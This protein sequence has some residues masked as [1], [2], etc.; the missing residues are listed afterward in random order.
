MRTPRFSLACA[1]ALLMLALGCNKQSSTAAPT[2]QQ[3]TSNVQAKLQSESALAGQNIQVAASNGVVTLTGS[4]NDAASRALAGNDAGAVPGV[5]TVVNNLE[6]QPAT[7]AAAAPPPAAEPEPAPAPQP[8]HRH[9]AR[10]RPDHPA[11]TSGPDMSQTAYNTP[12]PAPAPAN[13]ATSAPPPPPAPPVPIQRT[14]TLAA[15]TVVPVRITEALDS[16]HAQPD[17]AFHGTLAADLMRNG[18]V[19]IP[20]GTPVLGRVVDAKS[21]AHFKGSSL[22]SI[23]LTRIDLPGNKMSVFTDAFSKEGAGRGKNTAEKAGGGALLGTV[24]GALAGGGK[25][26]AIGAIAGAGAGTGINAATHGQQVQI[27]SETLIN[28]TL[29]QPLSFTVTVTPGGSAPRQPYEPT[30]NQRPP[31]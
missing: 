5:K 20:Q 3:L 14:I 27:P 16:E 23:E 21:A 13:S 28:F 25:G 1:A 18:T 24:I 17:Q 8:R 31:Q 15:G 30:L 9:D 26:A 4:A 29:Q 10:P 22:L 6:V 7:A 2:D 12:A 19:A 11:D